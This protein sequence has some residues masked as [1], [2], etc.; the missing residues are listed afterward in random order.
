M[1]VEFGSEVD[2]ACSVAVVENLNP[3]LAWA[4]LVE[5]TEW[6]LSLGDVDTLVSSVGVEDLDVH[7]VG[8]QWDINDEVLT[9]PFGVLA[10]IDGNGG[11]PFLVTN[12]EVDEWVHLVE[13]TALVVFEVSVSEVDVDVTLSVF[14]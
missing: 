7:L 1:G 9:V 13:K 2:F 10:T 8:E 14:R 3:F 5:E 6:N 12:A 11:V 4:A